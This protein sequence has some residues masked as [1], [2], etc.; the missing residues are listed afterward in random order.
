MLRDIT[1]G[2]HFPG[3]SPLHHMD[4]RAKIVLSIAYIVVLFMGSNALGLGLSVAFLLFLYGV[5]HIPLKLV[6][7]SLKPIIPIIIFTA[8]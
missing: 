3:T 1:I 2:Q 6:L 7:K 8:I 5:A 4:P